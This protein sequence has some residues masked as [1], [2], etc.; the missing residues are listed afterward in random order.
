VTEVFDSI[1][2][3]DRLCCVSG[4]HVRNLLRLL[5]ECIP[6]ERPPLS[7]NCLEGV[8]KQRCNELTLGIKDE[9]W[10]LLRQ[11]RQIKKVRGEEGYQSLLRSLFVFEYRDADGSWFDI[12]PVLAEAKEFKS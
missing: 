11:V 3:L 9:D 12:N 10:D 6:K 8:I 7:H 4:G 1:E 2:T 5:H